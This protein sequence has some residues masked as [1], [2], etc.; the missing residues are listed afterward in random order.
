MFCKII[1][2]NHLGVQLISVK[3]DRFKERDIFGGLLAIPVHSAFCCCILLQS[4]CLHSYQVSLL[5][6]LEFDTDATEYIL[7]PIK[8]VMLT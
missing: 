8:S 7:V 6:V 4:I 3:V 5:K 1:D 2:V